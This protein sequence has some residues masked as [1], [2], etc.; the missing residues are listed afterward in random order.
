VL[1]ISDPG[2][3]KASDPGSGSATLNIIENL[4]LKINTAPEVF[5]CFFL[6]ILIHKEHS[7]TT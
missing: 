1:F 7:H 6:E 5:K 3:K 4:G 2:V